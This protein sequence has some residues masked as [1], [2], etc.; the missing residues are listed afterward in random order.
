MKQKHMTE[1]DNDKLHAAQV[2]RY[3]SSQ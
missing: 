2:A 1:L 3:T